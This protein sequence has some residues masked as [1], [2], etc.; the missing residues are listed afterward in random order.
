MNQP[1]HPIAGEEDDFGHSRTRQSA[2]DEC[3]CGCACGCVAVAVAMT[4]CSVCACGCACGMWLR[5]RHVACGLW[6][7][8]ITRRQRQLRLTITLHYPSMDAAFAA[9]HVVSERTLITI[10][11]QAYYKPHLLGIIDAL[12]AAPVLGMPGHG[13]GPAAGTDHSSADFAVNDLFAPPPPVVLLS[14]VA[15]PAAF[16]DRPY[17]HLFAHFTLVAMLPVALYRS[18]ESVGSPLPYVCLLCVWCVPVVC[19]CVAVCV[20]GCV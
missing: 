16:V 17:L 18:R 5:V 4:I 13:T 15:V 1:H 10:T 11:A 12:L 19:V 20:C 2:E 7:V 9:G 14:S 3:V 8:F 6:I